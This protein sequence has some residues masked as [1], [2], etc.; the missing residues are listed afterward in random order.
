M[1]ELQLAI[2][3]PAVARDDAL[4]LLAQQSG[5]ARCAAARRDDKADHQRRSR[6]PQP[7][8]G[9]RL[10]PAGL[11]DVLGLGLPH[12]LLGLGVGRGQSRA[13]FLL[14]VAYRAQ[15][16]RRAQ[17][18]LDKLLD[19]PLADVQHAAEV[20]QGGRQPGTTTVGTDLVGNL[21]P[22]DMTTIRAGAAMS[23]VFDYLHRNLR[24]LHDLV[25]VG[26]RI[27]G[28]GQRGQWVVV[29]GSRRRLC[30]VMH[31]SVR[32]DVPPAVARAQMGGV[33]R[34]ATGFTPRAAF[35]GR[36][37]VPAAD[38]AMAVSTNWTHSGRSARFEIANARLESGDVFQQFPA[39]CAGWLVHVAMLSCPDSRSRASFAG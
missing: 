32:L 14:K 23:L 6:T 30:L 8:L 9:T 24:Q 26:L 28:S 27:V 19:A 11:I 31:G 4:D 33:S 5:Q 18:R 17:D 7:A 13:H 2:H 22:G 34:L 12:R 16:D 35:C 10:F 37:A 39:S 15:G 36:A 38:S 25:P 20:R 29:A 21:G 3:R 1:T